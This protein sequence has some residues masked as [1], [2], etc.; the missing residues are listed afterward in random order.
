ML[1]FDIK[2]D[3]YPPFNMFRNKCT[4]I[5]EKATGNQF[6]VANIGP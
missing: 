4:Y 1:D 3:A 6:K 2:G 5:G